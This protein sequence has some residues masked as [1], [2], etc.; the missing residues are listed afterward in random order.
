MAKRKRLGSAMFSRTSDVPAAAPETKSMPIA[1]VAGDAATAAA[2]AEVSEA[3]TAARR[4][5]RLVLALPL[6]AIDA[7]YL[8]RD[9]TRINATEMTALFDSLR[10]RGQQTPIEVTTLEGNRYGLIS[11]W[12]RLAALKELG[13]QTVLALVRHPQDASDAYLAMVEENEIRADLSYYERARIVLRAVEEGVFESDKSALLALFHSAS[14][15]KRSK[16][17]SF[18]PVVCHLSDVL[19]FPED[20]GER[21]GLRLSKAIEQDSAVI[22]RLQQLLAKRVADSNAEQRLIT[23]ALSK[24]AKSSAP[25]GPAV[26]RLTPGLRSET[27]AD[28]RL[29]L[30]GPALTPALQDRLQ[31]WLRAEVG[32]N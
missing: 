2:L 3:M 4:E 12:R 26:R 23:Q 20:L 21:L 7:N 6:H 16:I 19:Q 14:R 17:K 5:G 30:S 28:G 31:T 24:P 9:R 8:V 10:A 29:V 32:K 18:M 27:H 11:G 15:A 22:P 1:N 13:A 25:Q